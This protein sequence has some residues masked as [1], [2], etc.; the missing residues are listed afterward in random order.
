MSSVTK[1]NK[2]KTHWVYH[3]AM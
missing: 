1:V 2:Y 3:T